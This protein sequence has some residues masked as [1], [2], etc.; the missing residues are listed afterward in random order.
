MVGLLLYSR[1]CYMQAIRREIP[2][3]IKYDR[4]G[5]DLLN[6]ATRRTNLNTVGLHISLLVSPKEGER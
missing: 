3:T 1:H 5:G 6:E 2:H 4:S